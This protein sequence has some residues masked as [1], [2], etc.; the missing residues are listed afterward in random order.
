MMNKQE[1]QTVQDAV[2][3]IAQHGTAAMDAMVRACQSGDLEAYMLDE[4]VVQFDV[5]SNA[6]RERA[7]SSTY[8]IVSNQSPDKACFYG[9]DGLP[10]HFRTPYEALR[11]VT[12]DMHRYKGWDLVGEWIRCVDRTGVTKWTLVI[13]G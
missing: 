8:V 6:I 7:P 13:N 1:A 5:A 10:A 12:E 4:A 2:R 9:P 11:A 3:L